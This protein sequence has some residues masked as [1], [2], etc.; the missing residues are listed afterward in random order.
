MGKGKFPNSNMYCAGTLISYC[1]VAY[2][3]ITKLPLS[4]QQALCWY[5]DFLLFLIPIR[6]FNQ[7]Q[8]TLFIHQLP[9]STYPLEGHM[10]VVRDGLHPG[11]VTSLS[12]LIAV[13][14]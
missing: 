12:K 10:E 11:Q 8:W 6:S 13:P 4:R 1:M 3:F 14:K 2:P 7:T 5:C 9:K